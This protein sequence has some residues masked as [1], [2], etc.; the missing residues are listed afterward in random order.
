[1]SD[2]RDII[3]GYRESIERETAVRDA[4]FLG[5]SETVGPFELRPMTL[6]DYIVLKNAGSPLLGAG[7]KP[8]PEQ[9]AMFVWLLLEEPKGSQQRFSRRHWKQFTWEL[10]F[11]CRSYVLESF[12]DAPVPR[13]GVWNPDYYGD[14]AYFVT[15]FARHY[16]WE[17]QITLN[18]PMKQLFQF[19]N[20]I[21]S[22]S[23]DIMSNP[24]D[25]VR[26]AW[27]VGKRN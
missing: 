7:T 16:H 2:L 19:V 17:P 13:R 6:R 10:Y 4:A 25:G 24:S 26:A 15:L 21:R 8:S 14:G 20:E 5:I 22:K 9:L 1:M 11:A 18:L 12:Q 27:L 3:P 23:G